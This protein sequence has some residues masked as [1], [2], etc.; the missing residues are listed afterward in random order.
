[1]QAAPSPVE[2]PKKDDTL[3]RPATEG[4]QDGDLPAFFTE[5][6]MLRLEEGLGAQREQQERRHFSEPDAAAQAVGE[7][8]NTCGITPARCGA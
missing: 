5:G 6:A 8:K 3:I 2:A 1:L 7:R 4:A